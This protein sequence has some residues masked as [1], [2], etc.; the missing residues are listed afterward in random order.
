MEIDPIIFDRLKNA[1]QT[2]LVAFWD[3]L[4]HEQ[5]AV[6]LRDIDKIDFDHVNQSFEAIQ[7][8]L[9][10]KKS[11]ID[12]FMEPIPDEIIGSIDRTS[13]EQIEIYRREGENRNHA[14]FHVS[15]F[16]QWIFLSNRIKSDC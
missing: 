3:Q 8:Q 10:E 11:N 15:F 4:D 16:F 14:E 12:E 7:D 6:L 2:H 5:R 1:G 13:K 9:V